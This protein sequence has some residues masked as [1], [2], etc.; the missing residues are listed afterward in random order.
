VS[1]SPSNIS[2]GLPAVLLGASTVIFFILERV[3]PGR[4]LPQSRGWYARALGITLV[5]LAVTLV[6]A[7]LW[8]GVF[9][10]ASV[11]KLSHWNAPFLEGFGGWF[12]GTFFFYWWHRLRHARGW[13]LAFHQI[14]HSPARIEV[15][16]SFYKHPTEI[17]CDAILSAVILYPLLGCSILGAFWYNFFAGTGEYFYHANVRTPR[18]LRYVIQTPELH[19]VHHEFDAH[20]NNYGDIPLWDR[21]FGTYQDA[22]DFVPRCGFPAGAEG[23]LI[24]MLAFKDVYAEY[25]QPA[26]PRGAAPHATRLRRLQHG[27]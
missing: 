3:R 16:T 15:L 7:R 4:E 25:P 27:S 12:V 22:T 5:Q 1:I 21:M 9:G 24:P 26:A 8:S 11:F 17:L 13:W 2:L 10:G 20:R 23:R 14:H 6:T 18:W 19:S